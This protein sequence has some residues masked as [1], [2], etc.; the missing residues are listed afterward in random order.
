[1]TR[2]VADHPEQ[3][4]LWSDPALREAMKAGATG[5]RL[6]DEDVRAMRAARRRRAA[7]VASAA[8]VVVLGFGGWQTWMT[9]APAAPATLHFATGPGEMRT[10]ELTDGSSLHLNGATRLDVTLASGRR[11]ARL[12]AGEAYFD[13]AHDPAKPFIVHAGA[14][15]VRVL[16][17]AFDVDMIRD[18]VGLSVYRGAVRF[19]PVVAGT[20]VVVRAGYRTHYRHGRTEVPTHFDANEP[21]WRLGWLDTTGMKLADLVDVLNRQAGEPVLP[22]PPSLADIAVSGRFRL[23]NSR[24]LLKAIGSANGFTVARRTRGLEIM[25]EE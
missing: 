13:V 15:D 22:P 19:A 10:V 12:A 8:L 2:M 6:S 1:M 9:G 23:D 5:L 16:G 21:D 7:S 17:T 3:D 11:E 4:A 14:T 24:Q 25:P 18:Q 20:N